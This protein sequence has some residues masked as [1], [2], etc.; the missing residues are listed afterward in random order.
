MSNPVQIQITATAED[1]RKFQAAKAAASAA[2]KA[3]EQLGQAMGIPNAAQMAATLGLPAS[4]GKAEA[5]IIS[6]NGAP[7]GKLTCFWFGGSVIPPAY[8][9]RIS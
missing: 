7:I 2:A 1:W 9:N 3:A 5:V 6:G 4:E 8:R